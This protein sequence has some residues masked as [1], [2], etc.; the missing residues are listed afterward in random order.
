M[1]QMVVRRYLADASYEALLRLADNFGADVPEHVTRDE[2]QEIVDEAADEWDQ[3][4][5]ATNNDS[6]RVGETKYDNQPPESMDPA[7]EEIELPDSYNETR[8][9]LLLRDPS[10]AFTYW[11]IR[12]TDRIEFARSDSFEGLLI[13]VFLLPAEQS[14]RTEAIETF[15]IPVTLMDNRWYIN[16]PKQEIV[17]RLALYV[18]RDGAETELA[19]SNAVAVPRGM[20]AE[21]NGHKDDHGSDRIIAQTGIQDMDL[22]PSGKRI[23]QRI[24]DLIDEDLYFN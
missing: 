9:V 15:D 16:L 3:E 17:Y 8:V 18:L 2:L 1:V 13:R 5:R 11:D 23:P 14:D 21:R 12:E 7:E 10:W 20:L 4:H 19:L 6:V 22:P 24:L